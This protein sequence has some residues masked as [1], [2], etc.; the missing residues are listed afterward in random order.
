MGEGNLPRQSC[1]GE[2]DFKG[3]TRISFR[4]EILLK[5]V[6]LKRSLDTNAG[7]PWSPLGETSYTFALLAMKFGPLDCT[8]EVKKDKSC[9]AACCLMMR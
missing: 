8:P 9:V 6:A 3:F 1:S 7:K 5:D 2:V 4:R